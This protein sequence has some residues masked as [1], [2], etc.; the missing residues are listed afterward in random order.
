M[1]I[2]STVKTMYSL[3]CVT[4]IETSIN[5]PNISAVFGEYFCII[6]CGNDTCRNFPKVQLIICSLIF[7]NQYEATEQQIFS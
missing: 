5:K 2:Y 3:H 1:H 4:D 6:C 7:L